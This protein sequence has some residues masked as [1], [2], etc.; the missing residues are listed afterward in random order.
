MRTAFVRR[1]VLSASALSLALL[2][3]ACGGSDK[4]DAKEDTKPSAQASAPVSAPAPSAAP[5]AKAKTDAELAGLLVTQAELADH[6]FAAVPSTEV[7][8]GSAA[9]SD[10]AACQPVV[11]TQGTV[12][13][14]EALGVARTKAVAK[15]K[16]GATPLEALGATRTSVTLSSYDGKGAEEAFAA[17]K[18]AATACAGGF[19]LT[20]EGETTKIQK[21]TSNDAPI[22]DEAIAL[23]LEAD[24]EGEKVTSET[25]VVRKGNTLATHT[26]SSLAGVADKPTV[27]VAAQVKKLG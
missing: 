12:T 25:V 13:V 20:M 27:V 5:A 24:V 11:K 21:V 26:A 14:G 8:I 7:A 3:T 2:A 23:T 17:I 18:A 9:A 16:E 10:K 15:P 22:G 4:A 6:Q 19:T 1:T